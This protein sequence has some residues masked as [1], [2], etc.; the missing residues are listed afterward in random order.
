MEV[1]PIGGLCNRLRV[2]GSRLA[3]ARAVGKTLTV[4]WVPHIACPCRFDD[5]FEG[6][7]DLIVR[8]G[9]MGPAIVETTCMDL[10]DSPVSSW[11]SVVLE[12]KPLPPIQARI[13][14][15]LEKLGTDFTAVHI[16]RTDHNTRYEEDVAYATFARGQPGRVFAATDNPRSMATL[17]MALRDRLLYEG[18]FGVVG[19]RLTPVA[20]AVVDLWVAARAIAF[21]GTYYSSFSDWIEMM[22]SVY[23]LPA[24]DLSKIESAN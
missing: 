13:D 10:R 16:R 3:A 23:G 4:W 17:K 11:A 1:R 5:L 12:L 15:M 19:I 7:A 20:T 8:D 2:I 9:E 6:P 24:G 22:R 14:A 21:K 18:N